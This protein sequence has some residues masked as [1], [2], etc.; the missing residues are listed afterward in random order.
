MS[1]N[2]QR[3]AALERTAMF[4]LE[5]G[6]VPTEK[7]YRQ[8]GAVPVRI[9]TMRTY[10]KKWEKMVFMIETHQPK[11]WAELQKL[12]APKVV[13]TKVEKPVKPV[14]PFKAAVKDK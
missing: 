2:R 14:K 7:E 3:F 9:A 10:F 4:F 13:A 6:R 5:L 11:I 8:M 1:S 12:K